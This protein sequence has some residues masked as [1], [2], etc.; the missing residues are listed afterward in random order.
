MAAELVALESN[1]TWTVMPLPAG[2]RA[3]GCKWVYKVKC[4]A[5]GSL[6]KCKARLVAQGFT[7]QTEID[8]LETFSPVAKLTSVRI[9]LTNAAKKKLA[10]SAIGH[11]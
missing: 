1:N 5:D 4:N 2:K 11:Q 3:I 9:L 6:D 10:S 8:F 7:Q